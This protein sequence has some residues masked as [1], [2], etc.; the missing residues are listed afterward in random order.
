M[1]LPLIDHLIQE[2]NDRLL[3]QED[4]FLGQYLLP[5]KLQGLT[6]DVQDKMYAA[7]T[8][9]L[10]DKR[11]YNNEML[12]WKK[13]A[14]VQPENDQQLWLTLDCINPTLY[15]NVNVILTILFTMP[16]SNVNSGRNCSAIHSG[17]IYLRATMK[18]RTTLSSCSNARVLK[19]MTIYGKT[20]THAFCG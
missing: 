8:N 6:K 2:M 14:A 17:K 3:S 9:D 7:Y 20:V 11:E 1:Y 10:T 5:T 16:V 12:R 18:H 19:D 15:R 13:V 4:R